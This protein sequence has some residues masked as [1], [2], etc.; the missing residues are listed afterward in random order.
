MINPGELKEIEQQIG[1]INST[2]DED[3]AKWENRRQELYEISRMHVTAAQHY[4]Q[5]C[6]AISRKIFPMDPAPGNPI[7]DFANSPQPEYPSQVRMK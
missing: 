5:M 7:L 6:E 4:F 3:K 1:D 2:L